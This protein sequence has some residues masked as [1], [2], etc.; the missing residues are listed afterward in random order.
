[1]A[2]IDVI[3]VQRIM[4]RCIYGLS[5]LHINIVILLH[6]AFLSAILGE[7]VHNDSGR[8]ASTAG[9]AH[10]GVQVGAT[11]TKSNFSKTGVE[12]GFDH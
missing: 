9:T 6:A 5:L 2:L 10:W 7:L 12:R 11:S 1:M 4:L 8:D 3:L